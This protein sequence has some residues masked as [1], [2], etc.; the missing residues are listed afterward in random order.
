M[1]AVAL[2]LGYAAV[3]KKRLE[4]EKKM[5]RE[6]RFELATSTLARLHSTTEL[7]PLNE[8][9]IPYLKAFPFFVNKKSTRTRK[10]LMYGK[11]SYR[12]RAGGHL[13]ILDIPPEAHHIVDAR[14]DREKQGDPE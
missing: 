3:K 12:A 6:T 9:F 2:P 8:K 5:E 4:R 7:F 1:Q 14:P 10:D 13:V 11:K